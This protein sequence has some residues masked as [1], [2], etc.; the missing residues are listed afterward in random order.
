MDEGSIL[1]VVDTLFH[2]HAGRYAYLPLHHDVRVASKQ[3][4]PFKAVIIDTY[5]G[6][7]MTVLLSARE[8]L[9]G[10]IAVLR[11][12]ALV[13]LD[14]EISVGKAISDLEAAIVRGFRSLPTR[15]L[16]KHYNGDTGQETDWKPVLGEETLRN[17]ISTGLSA[18]KSTFCLTTEEFSVFTEDRGHHQGWHF[19]APRYE[20][21]VIPLTTR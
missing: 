13:D 19:K 7:E 1:T 5:V 21:N 12:P 16:S 3:K 17:A 4:G 14:N 9:H 11:Y 6:R 15:L 18:A 2:Y 20:N 8:D 10:P